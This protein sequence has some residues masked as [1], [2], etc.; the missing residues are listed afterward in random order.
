[1][2]N[3]LTDIL[4]DLDDLAGSEDEV[5]LGDVVD[6][7]GQRGEGAFLALP[8]L[9]GATPIGGIPGVP[10]LLGVFVV[11]ISAQFL[12]GKKGLWLPDM[13]KRRSVEDERITKSTKRLR[14]PAK[15]IDGHF[16]SR[17]QS[18]TGTPAKKIAALL[19]LIFGC[20]LP[21]L[22]VVPFA[23]LI[24]FAVIALLGL[25]LA[26]SDGLLMLI[27][28]LASAAGLWGIWAVQPF[29]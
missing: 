24:P 13:L 6:K 18:L 23:A 29:V 7:I 3:D 10:T 1:M 15:W 2:S 20:L 27:A 4:D 22:E 9:V 28:F 21:P 8:G 5:S 25:A 11:L 12:I 19:A 14:G 16:G 26:L 17:L